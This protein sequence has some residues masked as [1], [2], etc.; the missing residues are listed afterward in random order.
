MKYE[1]IRALL[2]P[3]ADD[4]DYL[5]IRAQR[6]PNTSRIH[7]RLG[8]RK[9]V[10][11]STIVEM[12]EIENF[13]S[14]DSWKKHLGYV[15]CD[16]T[17]ASKRDCLAVMKV[18][19]WQIISRGDLQPHQ[20]QIVVAAW[21]TA[22]N[23]EALSCNASNSV[24]QGPAHGLFELFRR[25]VAS[26][27]SCSI[28]LDGLDECE[29]PENPLHWLLDLLTTLPPVRLLFISQ[30]VSDVSSVVYLSDDNWPTI[31]ITPSDNH[32]DIAS[33]VGAR[34]PRVLVPGTGIHSEIRN[35]LLK[36]A[37]F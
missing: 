28:I 14:T 12:V 8:C 13:K 24:E 7:G 1:N 30:N 26:Y 11:A 15:F 5:R 6:E 37:K 4:S 22:S 2:S 18:L 16:K 29:Y 35:L 25:L 32:N 19:V 9:S 34:L 10:I 27:T 31:E 23:T 36:K 21:K 17:D 3:Q 20:K 33:Y